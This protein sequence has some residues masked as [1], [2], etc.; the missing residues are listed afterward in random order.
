[1][2]IG[3]TCQLLAKTMQPKEGRIYFG[4][5]FEEMCLSLVPGKLWQRKHQSMAEAAC[6]VTCSDFIK[7]ENGEFRPLQNQGPISPSRPAPK[8]TLLLNR[9]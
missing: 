4:S 9:Q 5:W 6:D 1:M 2:Q 8:D 3:A 7:S